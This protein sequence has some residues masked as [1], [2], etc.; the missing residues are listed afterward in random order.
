MEHKTEHETAETTP[1]P[2]RKAPC[3][4]KSGSNTSPKD[5]RD[6]RRFT[7]GVR[8]LLLATRLEA[9]IRTR[10]QLGGPP[11]PWKYV[12]FLQAGPFAIALLTALWA[13]WAYED[14]PAPPMLQAIGLAFLVLSYVASLAQPL[15]V[16]WQSRKS[17]MQ[18]L[19]APATPALQN[20]DVAIA[21]DRQLLRWLQSEKLQ[22][23]E[24][25]CLELKAEQEAL[26][27]RIGLTVGTIDKIGLVPGLLAALV[28]IPAGDSSWS[29]PIKALAYA[30]LP[31]YLLAAAAHL[32]QLRLDRLS[33]VVELALRRGKDAEDP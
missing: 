1:E 21:T 4:K 7:T 18:T 32:V 13:Y 11:L 16:V 30:I 26:A 10:R 23:L 20:I 27:K 31:L 24:L 5:P 14:K 29:I 9:R 19:R 17:I 8:A 22:D 33:R 6:R 2:R 15:V 3:D 25:L 12:L 28:A